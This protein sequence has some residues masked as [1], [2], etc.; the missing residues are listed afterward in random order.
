[1]VVSTV[2]LALQPCSASSSTYCNCNSAQLQQRYIKRSKPARKSGETDVAT[3]H[4]LEF[5]PCLRWRGRHD[6]AAV[7][8]P[9]NKGGAGLSLGRESPGIIIC[10]LSGSTSRPIIWAISSWLRILA[11]RSLGGPAAR[12]RVC[13]AADVGG[14]R[15]LSVTVCGRAWGPP[16][17][18]SMAPENSRA[19]DDCAG[20]CTE[21]DDA[22]TFG[23]LRRVASLSIRS[24]DRPARPKA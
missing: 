8:P 12:L 22:D 4:H 7:V 16:E 14:L 18:A 17:D 24:A 10:A 5:N 6:P 15:V 1:M 9:T 3:L 2:P 20:S 19:P 23:G 21:S 11:I 13:K